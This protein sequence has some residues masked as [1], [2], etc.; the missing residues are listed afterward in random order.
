MAEIVE[1]LQ[2]DT[3]P[4][5]SVTPL[6]LQLVDDGL[7]LPVRLPLLIA[8]GARP[9]PTAGLTAAVHG[10]ELNGIPVIWRLFDKLDPAQLKGTVIAVPVTNVLAFHRHSRLIRSGFDLNHHFPGKPD[11]NDVQVY[12]HRL[13]QRVIHHTDVLL[14]LHTASRGRENSLYVRADMH[15]PETAQ[16]AYLQRPQIILHNPASDG[17]LRGAA[18]GP[19]ITVEIGDP[20]RFQRDHTRRVTV[21]L[22]AVLAHRGM[23]PKRPVAMG[24]APVLCASSSWLY[25]DQGGLLEVIVGVNEPVTAK[26]PL[27]RLRDPFGRP[28]RTYEAPHDGIVI[29]RATDP[30][31]ETGARIVHLGRIADASDALVE[32]DD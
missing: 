20:A 21:G 30:V 13:L 6:W 2:L 29:G 18:Q 5:A 11:G 8:R 23:L 28:L 1:T 10:D 32:R 27:A 22:R 26:Q 9:G 16:L 15:D 4:P 14:D 3:L 31:A 25:T 19:A 7:G 12:A 24:P 17:T